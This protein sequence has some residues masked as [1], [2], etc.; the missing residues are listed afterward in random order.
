MGNPK[1]KV[2]RDEDDDVQICIIDGE[3]PQML[4]DLTA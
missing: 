3:N 4:R 1:S 2:A